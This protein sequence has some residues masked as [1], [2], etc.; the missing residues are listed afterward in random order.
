MEELI[1]KA[2]APR[3]FISCSLDVLVWQKH[4]VYW[5]LASL[6]MMQKYFRL[7]FLIN[8]IFQE[9]VLYMIK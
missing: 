3:Y 4:S 7:L 6:L 2:K 8:I 9:S 5:E 1:I